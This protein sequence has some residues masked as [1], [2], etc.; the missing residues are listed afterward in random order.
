MELKFDELNL[1]FELNTSLLKNKQNINPF[2]PIN[3]KIFAEKRLFT[4]KK[5]SGVV[6][7]SSIIKYICA[8][9][10]II[11]NNLLHVKP[12][13]FRKLVGKFAVFFKLN[14]FM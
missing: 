10:H 3:K 2:F 6:V 14:S 7:M 11:I 9:T 8:T 13:I 12:K 4:K 5:F 1:C